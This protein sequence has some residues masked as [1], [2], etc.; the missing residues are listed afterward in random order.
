ME[1]KKVPTLRVQRS[2]IIV[3]PSF[4]DMP[5]GNLYI[6]EVGKTIPFKIKRVYYINNLA[7]REAIRGRHAHRV[8]EQVLFCVSGSFLL[9]LDDGT[10]RQRMRLNNPALGVRIGPLLWHTMSSFSYDCVI[11]VFANDWY[12][13][14][15]YIRAYDEF[16][17]AATVV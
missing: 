1:V 8:L 16:L 12:R 9:H 10:T 2:G 15:D 3:L 4:E 7:N 5:D 6:A 17:Q 11:V 14:R 13:E